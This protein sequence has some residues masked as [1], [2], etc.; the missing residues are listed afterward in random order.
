LRSHPVLA[1]RAMQITS[2]HPET[3]GER[4][5]MSVKKWLLLDRIALHSGNV[6]PGNVKRAAMV[7]PNFA[8]SGLPVGN[9]AA[10]STGI[11]AHAIAIE[12][13]PECRVAFADA[14][15][16]RKNI[17]QRGHPCILRLRDCI[18]TGL[19]E[20]RESVCGQRNACRPALS[21]FCIL[22]FRWFV[23]SVKPKLRLL[24]G[25][26]YLRLGHLRS[27]SFQSR[28]A[29]LVALGKRE[30]RPEIRLG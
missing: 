29:V 3:V 23:M 24:P 15:V 6:A 30:R 18:C 26:E 7:K 19:W 4:A 20:E 13:L 9:W 25:G 1:V 8:D 14:L 12:F 22:D 21:T 2:E 17:L 27:Q 11:A 28:P 16:G 5:G 10:V